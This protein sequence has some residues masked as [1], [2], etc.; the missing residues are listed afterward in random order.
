MLQSSR[1]EYH[2][3]TIGIEQSSFTRSYFEHMCMNNI[4]KIYQQEGKCD[5]QQN[6]KDIINASILSTPEVFIDN[7][8][9][10]HLTL[11]PVKKPSARKSLCLFTNILDIQ[12]ETAKRRFVAEKFRRKSMKVCNS[13]WTKKNKTK[14]AF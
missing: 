8:P 1:L 6:L 3:K 13:L 2:M 14:R 7:I 11:S 12:H 4:K 5:N 10:V 9:N